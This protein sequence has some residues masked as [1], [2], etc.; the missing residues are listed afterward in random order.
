MNDDLLTIPETA[1]KLGCSERTVYRYV[2]EN[3]LRAVR[4]PT[5]TLVPTTE[6]AHLLASLNA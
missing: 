6:V 5:K 3:K 1:R 2:R 4:L